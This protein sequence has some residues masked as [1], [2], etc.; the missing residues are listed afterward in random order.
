MARRIDIPP[1]LNLE[2]YEA[3]AHLAPAVRQLRDEARRIVPKLEGRTLWMVNSTERGGGVAEMLPTLVTLLRDLGLPTEW[4]V[5]ESDE[6]AFFALTKRIHNLIHGAGEP[7]FSEEDRELFEKVNGENAREMAE[8]LSPGDLVLIHDPQPLAMAP[9]LQEAVDVRAI[10]RCHIGLDEDDGHTRSAWGFLS[11]YFN[12]YERGVFSAP[13]YVPEGLRNRSEIIHPAIDPLS[14]KNRELSIHK[15]VGILSNAALAVAP[16]PVLTPMYPYVA[17]RLQP[18][19][20]WAPANMSEDIGLP[21]RPIVA[22][23]SRW[24]RLKGWR[25]LLEAFAHLKNLERR[26]GDGER[27][28]HRRRMELVRLVLAGPDPESVADDPEGAEVLREL[29]DLYRDLPPHIQRDVALVALPMAEPDQNALMVNAIQRTSSVIVQNSI[30]EGFGL[31]VT[32]GMWKRVPVLSSFQACGPR[33]QVRDGL[34]GR[35]IADPADVREL[36]RAL[37]AMLRA[38]EDRERWGR[39]AQRRVH[40]R[41]LVFTQVSGWLHLLEQMMARSGVGR[42]TG[43]GS[44]G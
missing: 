34:D 38:Y 7:G 40:E 13:E 23:I 4:V 39:N 6:P 17:Q 16:S 30:R 11:P 44:G 10:W 21:S 3:V 5:L 1:R 36:C 2:E 27:H 26:S 18:D 15:V 20:R 8:W 28:L 32:E 31:T 43:G 24:D 33:Q 14:N 12:A 9:C 22:Q 35:M 37:D 41:F 29:S 19:G 25:P 42:G